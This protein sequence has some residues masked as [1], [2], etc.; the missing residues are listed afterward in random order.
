MKNVVEFPR[1]FIAYFNALETT[2]D[3]ISLVARPEKLH[4]K[5]DDQYIKM[6]TEF[7]IELYIKTYIMSPR[8]NLGSTTASPLQPETPGNLLLPWVMERTPISIDPSKAIEKIIT[9]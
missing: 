1:E 5:T 2:C 6:D 8:P 7:V 9:D 3:V 4:C